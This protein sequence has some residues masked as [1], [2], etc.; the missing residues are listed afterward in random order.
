LHLSLRFRKKLLSLV[1][2]LMIQVTTGSLLAADIEVE[3]EALADGIE[4]GA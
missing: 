2:R 3:R 4:E 1:Y